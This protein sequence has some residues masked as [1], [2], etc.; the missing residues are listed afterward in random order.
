MSFI[1]RQ[2]WLYNEELEMNSVGSN[3]AAGLDGGHVKARSIK[4]LNDG[5]QLYFGHI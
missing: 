4:P 5:G 2:V 1:L 3:E